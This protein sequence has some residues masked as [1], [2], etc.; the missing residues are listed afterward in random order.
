MPS[1]KK[2]KRQ[3]GHD[4]Q[5]DFAKFGYSLNMEV[6]FLNILHISF[7]YLLESGTM[8]RKKERNLAIFLPKNSNFMA[9][10]NLKKPLILALLIFNSYF[11]L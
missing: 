6:K 11:W 8:C 4:P 1:K 7:W 3:S 5:K 10:E 9:I 2:K